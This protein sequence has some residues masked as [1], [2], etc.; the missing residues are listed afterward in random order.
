M[1]R[2][3]GGD[4]VR[5]VG[6]EKGKWEHLSFSSLQHDL[7]CAKK[8]NMVYRN[9]FSPKRQRT[10]VNKPC[11]LIPKSKARCR[12]FKTTRLALDRQRPMLLE[13]LSRAH[14]YGVEELLPSILKVKRKQVGRGERCVVALGWWLCCFVGSGGLACFFGF[15]G[16]FWLV[17]KAKGTG[18][19]GNLRNGTSLESLSESLTTKGS[20]ALPSRQELLLRHQKLVQTPEKAKK[21]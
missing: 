10:N 5:W 18:L 8:T 9:M 2:A 21:D 12:R 3:K 1:W 4:C 19:V 11:Y 15:I 20:K 14:R 16:R 7:T 17:E 13:A 6:F